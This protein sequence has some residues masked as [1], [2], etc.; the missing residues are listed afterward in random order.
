MLKAKAKDQ[1][2][3]ILLG[4]TGIEKDNRDRPLKL[5]RKINPPHQ[6]RADPLE[7]SESLPLK[8]T[9]TEKKVYSPNAKV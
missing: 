3:L 5:Q 9:S 1:N 2:A 8:Y 4:L 6:G 7:F